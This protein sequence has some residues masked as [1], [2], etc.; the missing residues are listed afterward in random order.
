MA[1]GLACG[2]RRADHHVAEQNGDGMGHLGRVVDG[3][4][5]HVCRPVTTHVLG[6]EVGHRTLVDEVQV[7]L[8]VP[9]PQPLG[10]E[11][12][13]H[14]ADPT[15][16]VDGQR[17]V[18]FAPLVVDHHPGGSV[19]GRSTEPPSSTAGATSPRAAPALS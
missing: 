7:D 9:F 11:H 17:R 18:G 6:V 12:V 3:E 16:G 13:G 15:L 19:H 8:Q 4:R 5:Q 14:E 2:H 10:T 1:G